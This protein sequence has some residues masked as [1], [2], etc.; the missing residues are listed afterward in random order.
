MA[1]SVLMIAALASAGKVSRQ[2]PRGFFVVAGIVILGTG[3]GLLAVRGKPAAIRR[4]DPV[5]RPVLLVPDFDNGTGEGEFTA[6]ARQLT[7]SVRIRLEAEPDRI[8]ELSARRLRPAFGPAEREEGLVGI[9]GRLGADYVL[10]GSLESGPGG[11]LG[12]GS[13]WNAPADEEESG[14]GIRL[15]VLLVR[16]SDPPHVFAERFPLGRPVPEG[17]EAAALADWVAERIVLSLSRP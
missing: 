11:T 14:G 13:S 8:F 7:E 5:T 12:P 10:V 15:D 2:V 9:A 17:A 4:P 3:L 16:D 6:L 1:E